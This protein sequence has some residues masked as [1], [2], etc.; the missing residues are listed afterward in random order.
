MFADKRDMQ[1]YSDQ[2]LVLALIFCECAKVISGPSCFIKPLKYSLVTAMTSVWK[3]GLLFKV[4]FRFGIWQVQVLSF[5][6]I[7]FGINDLSKYHQ[8]AKILD[9]SASLPKS[10]L[11]CLPLLRIYVR[12]PA[13]VGLNRD[14]ALF[15]V[16]TFSYFPLTGVAAA[17]WCGPTNG[18][19][20]RSGSLY[21][22]S[23]HE[24]LAIAGSPPGNVGQRLS[25]GHA[26]D[27][28]GAG[29]HRRH[30]FQLGDV[31]LDWNGTADEKRG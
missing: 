30:V 5:A 6:V 21:L 3:T 19:M 13:L 1:F 12:A 9:F 17:M 8:A 7:A 25:L 16:F 28:G 24:G 23:V 26:G 31:G 15:A 20:D 10:H 22:V 2:P 11:Y 14:L 4:Q 18:Q 29:L 27:H